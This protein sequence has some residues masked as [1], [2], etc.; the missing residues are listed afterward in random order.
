[1][2]PKSKMDGRSGSVSR[3]LSPGLLRGG[4]HSSG[5]PVIRRLDAAYPRGIPRRATSPLLFG[6]APGGVYRA[7]SVTRDAV[8]SYLAVSPLPATGSGT[9]SAGGLLSVALSVGFP[10]LGVTQHPALRSSDFP[11]LCETG[12]IARSTPD[13]SSYQLSAISYQQ[14]PNRFWLTASFRRR[15][16]RGCDRSSRTE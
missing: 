12:A 10:L 16:T 8:S 3:I 15:S 14:N 5:A 7:V 13:I 6:L 1:M 4:D 2:S 11:H 9:P